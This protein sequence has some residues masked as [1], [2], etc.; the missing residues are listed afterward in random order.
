V[1][2]KEVAATHGKLL[3]HLR[4]LWVDDESYPEYVGGRAS[5]LK[6]FLPALT[7]GQLVEVVVLGGAWPSSTIPGP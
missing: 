1:G 4:I 5:D 6:G 3:H 2:D 7:I